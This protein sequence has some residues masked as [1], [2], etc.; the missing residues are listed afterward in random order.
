MKRFIFYFLLLLL[1]VILGVS[2][3]RDPGY[4][5]INYQNWSIETTLWFAVLALI[6]L[7]MLFYFFLRIFRAASLLTDNWHQWS[8]R[9]KEKKANKF[10]FQGLCQLAEGEWKQAEKS[11]LRGVN[12]T[13][14][15]LI[16]YLA[17]A[18][19]AQHQ[20]RFEERD[21]YLRL[22]HQHSPEA[23]VAIA[24]TQAQLQFS[25]KQWELALATLRHLQQLAPHQTY[26]L[27]LLK[28]VYVALKDWTSLE[29]LIPELRR[30]KVLENE[31]LQSLEQ[32]IYFE[33][34]KAATINKPQQVND[35]WKNIP[36]QLQS[37]PQIVAFYANYLLQQKDE[38]K[39]EN[40][41]REALKKTW[42]PSLLVLYSNV[43]S[44]NLEKQI[45]QAEG[46]LK[47]HPHD[48]PLLFCLGKLSL[49]AQAW[50][51]ARDYFLASIQI[52]PRSEALR[53]LGRLYEQRHEYQEAVR[54]YHQALFLG[55][56]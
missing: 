37:D 41:L 55:I 40:L 42:E 34:L 25:A 17:A 43:H 8:E 44:D 4:V 22:A 33:L 11:L 30:H 53:E 49:Y 31:Q 54:Y 1:V 36:K 6:I 52:E 56:E 23:D 14:T 26:V 45:A 9:R 29:Q 46:W 50:D 48:A 21:N 16:N 3:H 28:N 20:D 51:K 18:N 39:V 24:L 32:L 2:I 19:A 13:E 27:K 10:T 5:L 47:N 7:F 15:P 35:V 12:H 38:N